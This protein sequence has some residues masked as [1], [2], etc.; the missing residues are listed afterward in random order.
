VTQ[1]SAKVAALSADDV[2][3]VVNVICVEAGAVDGELGDGRRVGEPEGGRDG[4]KCQFSTAS[5]PKLPADCPP[6]LSTIIPVLFPSAKMRRPRVAATAPYRLHQLP[7]TE[8]MRKDPA[9]SLRCAGRRRLLLAKVSTPL[10]A[11]QKS[12]RVQ[13]RFSKPFNLT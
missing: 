6:L 3:R 10:R 13:G 5:W 1:K 8:E 11:G 9:A 7:A 12:S 2:G 4:P